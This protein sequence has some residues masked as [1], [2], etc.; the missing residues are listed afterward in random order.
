MS[1]LA[2]SRTPA[3]ADGVGTN[4]SFNSPY[5]IVA[6]TYGNVYVADTNNHRIRRINSNGYVSTLAGS[7]AGYADGIGTNA[8]FNFP[9]HLSIDVLGTMYV[10]D[11]NNNRIRKVTPDGV[12]TTL[13]GDGTAGFTISSFNNPQGITVDRLRNAYVA[14]T[15]NHSIRRITNVYTLPENNGVVTTIAGSG[16]PAITDGSGIGANFNAPRGLDIDQEG[17]VFVADTGNNRIRKIT[18]AGV[19]TIYAGQA[20]AGFLDS[21]GTNARFNA[22]WGIAVDLL[23]NVWVGDSANHRV[24]QIDRYLTVSSRGTGSTTFSSD[25]LNTPQQITVSRSGNVFVADVNNHRIRSFT[26]GVGGFGVIAGNGTVSSVDGFRTTATFNRPEGVAIASDGTMYVAE[27]GT[28]RIRRITPGGYVSTFAGTTQGFLDG[29]GTNARFNFPRG[30]AVGPDDTIY[31]ADESNHRI[32]KIT[33]SG[34]VTTLAGTTSGFQN[35]VGTNARF[36]FPVGIAVDPLGNLYIGDRSNNRIRKIGGTAAQ[37]PPNQAIVTTIA[38]STTEGFQNGVGS[39]ALFYYPRGIALGPDGNLYVADASNN[40]IR[41]VTPAG[42]VTTF[43]GQITAGFTNGTGTN[44]RFNF[45]WMI[46]V[47]SAGNVYVGDETNN[48]IRKITPLGVVSTFVGG[49][50]GYADGVGVNARFRYIYSL[51]A[52]SEGN[53]WVCDDTNHCIRK[54]T[55]AGVVSTFA[56]IGNAASGDVTNG[57]VDGTGTNARFY[58]PEG[59]AMN[60]KMDFYVLD[61]YNYRIRKITPDGVV[62]TFAGNGNN[63]SVDGVGTNA[64]FGGGIT[65]ITI[66]VSDNMYITERDTNRIRK[67]TP[68]GVVTTFAGG[69]QGSQD[70]VGTNAHIFFPGG[71]TVTRDG[72]L[73]IADTGNSRIRKIV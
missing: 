66:D 50:F 26:P 24:R 46:T 2:G 47:D 37:L 19:V 57:Y 5:G 1:T 65:F 20:T 33:P 6:D 14:D 54:V 43:A 34:V 60:S 29:V 61:H 4:A 8:L 30:I 64:S 71:I 68:A 63:A 21:T 23:G 56:G 52:D 51:I 10:A 11:K 44:A 18:P 22:P 42:V 32:R 9:H 62:T 27:Y 15:G 58:Y 69:T 35:G 36:N 16:T 41:R 12:V 53:L 39:S 70:G 13:A 49:T 67:I 48:C 31:V 17:N 55:P 73:Y 3:F 25:N 45:P 72:T 38:G 28:H 40:A 59:I 7:T